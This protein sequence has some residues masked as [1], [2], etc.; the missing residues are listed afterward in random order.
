M[1][2]TTADVIS[3]IANSVTALVALAGVIVAGLGLN[4][5]RKQIRGQSEYEL[6]KKLM[7]QVYQLRDAL[8]DVR[9]PF[10][11]VQEADKDSAEKD[12]EISAYN[13]RLKPVR[14]IIAQFNVS[15]LEA[16]VVWDDKTANAKKALLDR[17]SRL[18]VVVNL[19]FSKQRNKITDENLPKDYSDV[20][21]RRGDDK[22]KYEKSLDE[23]VKEYEKV[24]KPHLRK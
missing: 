21:Y 14:E 10:L 8:Q 18:H 22:D 15:Q 16:E 12:W 11:S 5:W 3:S 1:V 17:V 20:L 4:T 6:A 2:A 23:A 13:N 19:Y 7:L 9:N 24:L